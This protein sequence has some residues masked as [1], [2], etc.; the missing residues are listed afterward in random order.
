MRYQNTIESI[1]KDLKV[2]FV[3]LQ[4]MKNLKTWK[5]VLNNFFLIKKIEVL[6]KLKKKKKICLNDKISTHK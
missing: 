3:D 2:L 1:C 6:P 4:G 5:E